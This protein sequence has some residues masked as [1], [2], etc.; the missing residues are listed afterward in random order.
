MK[1]FV[2]IFF[3]II[4]N[5]TFGQLK[6]NS[7][8]LS[9]SGN[10]IKNHYLK[11]LDTIFSNSKILGLGESTHGTSEFS[12]I[13]IDIF[14]YL[15]QNHNYTAFFLEADYGACSRVNRLIHGED[16][17]P[18]SA[19]LEVTLW[20]WQTKELLEL[21]I[22]MRDYNKTNNN[23]LEFIG[24]DM[25]L[26]T[27]DEIEMKRFLSTDPKYLECLKKLPSLSFDI[28]DSLI[29]K[30]KKTEWEEFTEFYLSKFP[31]DKKLRMTTVNQWFEKKINKGFTGNFRDSC[32]ANNIADYLQDN[33]EVKGIYFAHNGHISKTK[34]RYDSNSPY[35][36]RAG[37]FLSE[38][39][40][41]E[42]YA[43]ALDFNKGS[44]NAINFKNKKFVMEYFV[45]KRSKHKTISKI[46]LRKDD[47]IKFVESKDIPEL[48]LKMN[49]IGALYGKN[50]S[51]NKIYR[52]RKLDKKLYDAYII[53]NQGTPTKLLTIESNK[54]KG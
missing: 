12:V 46:V 50:K 43:I 33:P 34:R 41:S 19:L 26:I 5:Q 28:K 44:F 10:V 52:Y 48:D 53:I 47:C 30:E 35:F 21:V 23:I 51:G 31:N 11:K 15:V 8:K 6:I 37:H 7:I 4:L 25:Q 32:M 17:N 16:D 1:I 49:S 13:R 42:Y 38:R 45:F 3:S 14:K 18:E 40:N 54:H 39:L 36:K 22:W 2:F 27:D 9:D 20:P 29:I 24:C